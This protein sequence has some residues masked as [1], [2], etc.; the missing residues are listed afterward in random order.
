M[1]ALDIRIA[2]NLR[3]LVNAFC[4]ITK[5]CLHKHHATQKCHLKSYFH[6]LYFLLRVFVA[7][8]ASIMRLHRGKILI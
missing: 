6:N 4:Q 5:L 8:L 1:S 7:C 2:D 3:G